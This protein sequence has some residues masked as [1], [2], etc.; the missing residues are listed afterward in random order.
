MTHPFAQLKA[1]RAWMDRE[2]AAR[3]MRLYWAR[4]PRQWEI[5]PKDCC[6]ARVNTLARLHC[7]SFDSCCRWL[8]QYIFVEVG[9]AL[10]HANPDLPR[11]AAETPKEGK[12]S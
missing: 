8:E 9:E 12:K 4:G 10:Y 2:L 5:W 11:H 3:D 6:V 7:G 1:R